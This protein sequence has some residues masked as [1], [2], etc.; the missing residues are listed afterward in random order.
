MVDGNAGQE[1]YFLYSFQLFLFNTKIYDAVRKWW[2]RSA[3]PM[4]MFYYAITSQ[5]HF[6]FVCLCLFWTHDVRAICITI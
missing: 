2:K 4:H 1:K 5:R 6:A 3:E